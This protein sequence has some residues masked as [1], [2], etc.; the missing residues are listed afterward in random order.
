MAAKFLILIYQHDTNKKL[1]SKAFDVALWQH[2]YKYK[3]KLSEWGL[4]LLFKTL[5]LAFAD[6]HQ[7]V[8]DDAAK[9]KNKVFNGSQKPQ[10]N[11]N[12]FF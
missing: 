10:S 3:N 2:I 8:D 9:A 1:D 6:C 5:F 4:E 7:G 12:L 11:N